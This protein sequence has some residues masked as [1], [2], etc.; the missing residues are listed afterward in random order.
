M[1]NLLF[2]EAI[3]HLLML[4]GLPLRRTYKISTMLKNLCERPSGNRTAGGGTTIRCNSSQALDIS[5][6][7]L[8]AVST[9]INTSV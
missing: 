7:P 1:S 9:I 6:E 5:N 3:S 4:I 8:E 2:R